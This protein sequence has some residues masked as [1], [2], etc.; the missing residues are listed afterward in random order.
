MLVGQSGSSEAT[1]QVQIESFPTI[2]VLHLERFL[3]DAT[4]DGMVKVGKAIRFVPE[5]EI[6]L[7]TIFSLVF[8]V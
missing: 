4:A 7:G 5:V 3:Y 1:Q 8:P 2:L 6:P